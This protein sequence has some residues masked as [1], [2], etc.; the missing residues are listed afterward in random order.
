MAGIGS[1]GTTLQEFRNLLGWEEPND[2]L[3]LEAM[4]QIYTDITPTTNTITLEIANS[5]WQ[6]TGFTVYDSYKSRIATYFDG[7]VSELDFGSPNALETINSWI[8]NKTHGKVQDM[9]DYIPSNAVLYLINAIYFKG[10]WKYIFDEKNT[11]DNNF[12]KIDG[13]PVSVPFMKQSTAVKYVSNDQFSM[14]SLPYADS[15]YTMLILLPSAQTGIEGMMEQLTTENWKSWQQQL[16]YDIVDISIPKFKF[17]YGTRLINDELKTLGLQHA[18]DDADFS[19][20]TPEGVYISRVLHKAFIEI[21]EKGSEAAAATIVEIIKYN[22]EPNPNPQFIA[23]RPFLFA[24]CHQP[25][26]TILFVGKVAN[27]E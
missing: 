17:E 19:R 14:I 21:N 15:S 11:A 12:Y 4:Q 22:N 10:D 16:T 23:N 20:M 25:T 24:I 9:L 2:T 18:F 5:L 3:V 6:R 8:E 1:D 26:S 27:P 7:E 13:E